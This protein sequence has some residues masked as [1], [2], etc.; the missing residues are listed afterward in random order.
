MKV[1]EKREIWAI[2]PKFPRIPIKN[3]KTAK[4]K[5]VPTQK[6]IGRP[7]IKIV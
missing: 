6:Y 7:K 1:I 2:L 3:R 4:K 5:I